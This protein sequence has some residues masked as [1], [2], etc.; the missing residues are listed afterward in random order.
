MTAVVGRGNVPSFEVF[1]DLF[2]SPAPRWSA[3]R[4]HLQGALAV[5]EGPSFS[6]WCPFQ[7]WALG[8]LPVPHH[9]PRYPLLPCVGIPGSWLSPVNKQP[10]CPEFQ[11][12]GLSACSSLLKL[13][14][15]SVV[16]QLQSDREIMSCDVI[17]RAEK[18]HGW[19]I[20]TQ[21]DPIHSELKRRPGRK[22]VQYWA[23]SSQ[24][25]NG[26]K[27][28]A[29]TCLTKIGEPEILLTRLTF[30]FKTIDPSGNVN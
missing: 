24:L 22:G 10:R 7:G 27:T 3:P 14:L 15:I 11:S 16:D 5:W 6:W 9:P 20:Q 13:Y 26:G 17:L 12:P 4:A 1:L 30:S 18:S 23:T 8:C 2:D 29:N 25:Q 19:Q 21:D 28:H